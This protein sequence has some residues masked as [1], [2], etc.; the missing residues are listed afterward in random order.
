MGGFRVPIGGRM[1]VAGGN[2][3][4]QS[5]AN[6]EINWRV[7]FSASCLHAAEAIACGQLIADQRLAEAIADPAQELRQAVV[8]AGLPRVTF[9]RHLVGLSGTVDNNRQLA[10][11]AIRKTIGTQQRNEA[12]TSEI[13]GHITELEAAVRLV[14]PDLVEELSVRCRP[15]REQWEARGPGLLRSITRWTDANVIAPRADVVLVYPALGGGGVAHLPYNNVRME[16][17]LTNPDPQLP[18][19]VRLGWLLGQLNLDLPAYSESIRGQRL[20]HIAEL[21]MLP[22][23]LQA[24]EDVELTTVDQTSLGRALQ[25]WHVVTPPDLDPVDVLQRWWGTYLETR[26]RWDIALSALD[27]MFG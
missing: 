10:E 1:H 26:P 2:V 3:N 12:L 15:L 17:V 7:S 18:E 8:N 4:P 25:V 23:A 19:V 6:M 20:P 9:W 5:T 11:L 16:G 24:A 22:V 21:A 14:F 13:G 27:R